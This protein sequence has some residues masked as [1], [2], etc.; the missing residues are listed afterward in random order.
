MLHL[1]FLMFDNSFLFHFFDYSLIANNDRV[2]WGE[3]APLGSNG[4]LFSQNNNWVSSR[5]IF[6]VTC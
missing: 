4:I 6:V 1:D 5:Y 2:E 3:N